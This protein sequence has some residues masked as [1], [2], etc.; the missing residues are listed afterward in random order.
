[1]LNYYLRE[2]AYGPQDSHFIMI[3]H[4]RQH[5]VE[6]EILAGNVPKREWK[7]KIGPGGG[8]LNET[9]P[10]S[11][12]LTFVIPDVFSTCKKYKE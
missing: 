8:K 7:T 9:R 2:A 4:G 1:V 11:S 6:Y 12:K 10:Q 3:L 5:F